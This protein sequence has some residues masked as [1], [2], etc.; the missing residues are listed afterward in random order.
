[1]RDREVAER[2]A[3]RDRRAQPAA[4]LAA[5]RPGEERADEA[6]DAGR[7]PVGGDRLPVAQEPYVA[8]ERVRP[9]MRLAREREGG[10]HRER[11]RD[12]RHA[13]WVPCSAAVSCAA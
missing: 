3:R 5:R 4:T 7:R 6:G 11:E 1:M 13:P 10:C 2:R 9:C 12:A 8:A